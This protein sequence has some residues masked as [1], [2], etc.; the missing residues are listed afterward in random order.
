M[1]A[2][3]GMSHFEQQLSQAQDWTQLERS[4]QEVNAAF[5]AGRLNAAQAESLARM[6][7]RCS[8]AL[9]AATDRLAA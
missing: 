5:S 7:I 3:I 6:S 1:P 4:I 2:Q 8:R 9:P